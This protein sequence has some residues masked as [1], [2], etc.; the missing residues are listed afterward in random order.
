MHILLLTDNFP[1]ENNAPAIRCYEHAR[2][3]VALG[4]RVTVI[5][6][7]PNFPAGRLFPGYRQRLF[8]RETITGIDVIRVPTFIF[9]NSGTML[10]LI[11]FMS[12]MVVGTLASLFVRRPDVVLATSPQFFTA[13]AGW[14][15][16]C[17]RR[18]PFVFELRDLWPDSVIA[19]GAMR[20]SRAMRMVR[21][22]EELLYERATAIVALTH[23]FKRILSSRG[24]NGEK[25]HVIPNG[26]ASEMFEAGDIPDGLLAN[27]KI[28]GCF[29]VSYIGTIGL[30][31]DIDIV[32]EAADML[33]VSCPTVRIIIV[34]N[35]AERDR[36]KS[37]V[38]SKGIWNISFIDSVPHEQIIN[39]WRISDATMVLLRDVPLFATVLPSKIFEAMATGTPIISNVQ[40][41]AKDLL[42]S[43]GAAELIMP[44]DGKALADAIASL[45]SSPDHCRRLA[46]RGRETA[47][48]YARPILARQVL[49]VL[50]STQVR[51]P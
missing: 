38:G 44:A 2:E 35:G 19:V 50:E 9:Q 10:R 28:S 30:A 17:L 20:E 3:W 48:K 6:C 40:G 12:F 33:A 11:D 27:L 16:S 13:V 49:S 22:L 41:E 43:S 14:W 25:V 45:A 31:H 39:Y 5:T 15:V 32:L 7:F 8:S 36:L 24:V 37:I 1:P 42:L 23:S 51:N 21:G 47:L 18:C 4:Q 29:V 34:G 46:Q 26:A